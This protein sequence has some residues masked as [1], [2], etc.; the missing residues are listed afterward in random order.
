LKPTIVNAH[1]KF[2]K[3]LHPSTIQ[4]FKVVPEE[5]F[6]IQQTGTAKQVRYYTRK[7]NHPKFKNASAYGALN[8][9]ED[10]E[11]GDVLKIYL[12]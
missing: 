8:Y 9:L 10:K 3:E 2:L 7:I 4:T 11:N 12:F 6:P 5:D 1:E